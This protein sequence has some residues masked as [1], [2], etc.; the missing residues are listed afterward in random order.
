MVL[1]ILKILAVLIL[2]SLIFVVLV[3]RTL[4]LKILIVLVLLLI[5]MVGMGTWTVSNAVKTNTALQAST[6]NNDGSNS[7]S[8]SVVIK[9]PTSYATGF[10]INVVR[11]NGGVSK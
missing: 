2:I 4:A 9:R 8:F 5:V 1:L 11:D 3:L 10:S 6:L 7:E